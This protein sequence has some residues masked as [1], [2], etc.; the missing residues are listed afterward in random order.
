MRV[1]PSDAIEMTSAYLDRAVTETLLAHHTRSATVQQ[2]QNLAA[3]IHLCGAAAGDLYVR[4]AFKLTGGQKCGDEEAR[5]YVGRVN[6]MKRLF[7]GL[8]AGRL[9]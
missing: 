9:E 7:A 8:S 3:V 5:A 6:A 4:R 2:K 1:I